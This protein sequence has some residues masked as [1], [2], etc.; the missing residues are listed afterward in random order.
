MPWSGCRRWRARRFTAW[1][2]ARRAS[3]PTTSSSWARRPN[4][5]A[6]S[7]ARASTRRGSPAPAAPAARSPSGSS[8]AGR[9]W[10]SGRSTSVASPGGTATSAGSASAWWRPWGCTTPWPGRCATTRADAECGGRRSTT[11]SRPRGPP[12]GRRWAGSGPTGSPPT[13]PGPRRSTPSAARTGSPMRPP[14]IARPARPSPCSTRPPSPS[15]S[16]RDPM[17]RRCSSGCAPTTSP[18]RPA[19]WSTRQCS[20]SGAGTSRT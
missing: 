8:R 19:R 10:I 11:G 14:S 16:S 12:S 17:P 15:S 7:S 1:S 3:R 5:A 18:C 6:S 20:A 2:M 4:C 13:V 9:P